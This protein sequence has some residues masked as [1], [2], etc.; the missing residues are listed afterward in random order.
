[1]GCPSAS[2]K[3]TV[4]FT[5]LVTTLASLAG[6]N[7]GWVFLLA[8]GLKV[9]EVPSYVTKYANEHWQPPVVQRRVTT[10]LNNYKKQV[11]RKDGGDNAPG[12]AGKGVLPVPH[13]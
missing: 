13:G 2:S 8:A 4:T 5:S 9:K 10:W 1:M 6:T 3:H 11:E 7:V 12:R